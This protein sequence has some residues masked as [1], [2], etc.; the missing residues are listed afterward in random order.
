MN[1]DRYLQFKGIDIL[2]K[3][4][5]EILKVFCDK[6]AKCSG[7]QPT[8]SD[9]TG[10]T[11]CNTCETFVDKHIPKHTVD[12]SNEKEFI[13][14]KDHKKQLEEQAK[15]IVE[16]LYNTNPEEEFDEYVKV[17]ESFDIKWKELDFNNMNTRGV[18]DE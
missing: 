5:D 15:K 17:V 7:E 11:V 1:E 4:E 3:D 14:L 2:Y 13:T 12:E 8:E 6:V 16:K 9:N 10:C 18:N